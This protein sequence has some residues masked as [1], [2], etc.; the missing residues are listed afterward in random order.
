MSSGQDLGLENWERSLAE[1][2]LEALCP[3]S[4]WPPSVP[5]LEGEVHPGSPSL[6]TPIPHSPKI[7]HIAMVTKTEHLL[8]FP[9]FPRRT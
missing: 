6:P 3:E 4:T 7:H 8:P 2:I 9:C 5:C 1:Y